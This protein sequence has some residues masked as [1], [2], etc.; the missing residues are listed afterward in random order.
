MIKLQNTLMALV[1][2]LSVGLA[3]CKKDTQEACI[4]RSST[5]FNKDTVLV[6]DSVYFRLCNLLAPKSTECIWDFGDGN[7]ATGTEVIHAWDSAGNYLVKLTVSGGKPDIAT[8]T[9]VVTKADGFTYVGNFNCA[10]TVFKDDTSFN[11]SPYP[12]S[13]TA[14][15]A[16]AI[17][18]NN[19]L[20]DGNNVNVTVNG[21]YLFVPIQIFSS[22][23]ISG[24]GSL[25]ANQR[26]IGIIV[27]KSNAIGKEIYSISLQR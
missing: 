25:T 13:I 15:T 19:L 6:N 26:K 22:D 7:T 24:S 23:T 10:S 9:I 20:N 8:A 14:L 1:F 5:W 3:S 27:G 17:V 18:I 21:N 4:S 11:L 12:A 16:N 2:V